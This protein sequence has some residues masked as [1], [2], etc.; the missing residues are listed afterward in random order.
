MPRRLLTGAGCALALLCMSAPASAHHAAT[1]SAT[2]SSLTLD[3][4]KCKSS[5]RRATSRCDGTR[6]ARVSWTA[7]CGAKPYDRRLLGRA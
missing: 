4:P 3:P 5:E 6:V 1:V 7:T 2:A